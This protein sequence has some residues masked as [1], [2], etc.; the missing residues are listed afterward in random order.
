M[1][2]RDEHG[3]KGMEARDWTHIEEVLRRSYE[4]LKTG[5]NP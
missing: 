2:Y 5:L 3:K 1:A 4:L